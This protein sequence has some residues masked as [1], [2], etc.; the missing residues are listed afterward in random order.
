MW[1]ALATIGSGILGYLGQQEANEAN[2][3]LGR[4]QMAFQERMSGTAYQR[5]VSDMKA[6]GLNPML[7]YSQGGASSPM[8]AMPQ[9]QNAAAAG[10]QSAAVAAGVQLI[11]SQV[12]KTEAEAENVKTDTMLKREGHLP[13]LT[14]SAF[15]LRQSGAQIEQNMQKFEDE[16]K[17]LR[18]EIAKIQTEQ[19]YISQGTELRITQKYKN[20]F[21]LEKIMPQQAKRLMYEAQLAGLKVP[22]ALRE[23]AF[24]KSDRGPWAVEYRH[25]PRGVVPFISGTLG[26]TAERLGEA[27]RGY[28]PSSD[29]KFPVQGYGR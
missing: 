13:Q 28:H 3:Q 6:A 1:G 11:K 5:A 15:Q 27:L 21:E 7:A 19:R 18:E 16:W 24:W 23:A 22:E 14:A 8:G 9:V 2:I 25:S 29:R 4:D 20:I 17:K 10:G 12:E 26:G